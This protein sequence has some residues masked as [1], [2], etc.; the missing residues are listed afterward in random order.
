MSDGETRS[1]GRVALLLLV[2][3][4]LRL[5]LA[6]REAPEPPPAP[7]VLPGLLAESR[8]RAEEAAA[9]STPLGPKEQLDPNGA[10]AAELDRLPGVGPAIAEALVRSREAEG[11]FGGPEDLLRVP[12][13]G[14]ALLDRIRPHLALAPS[15]PAAGRL[16]P[17]GQQASAPPSRPAPARPAPPRPGPLLDVN[18]ADTLALQALP[19]VGPVLARRI[20]EARVESP[21]RSVDDLLRVRG[22]GPATLSRL[23]PLVTVPR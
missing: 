15:A 1:L 9:R 18:R 11:P 14:P 23:R 12:R 6:S 22:I 16:R 19:G 5:G 13:V 17:R 20:V 21:F 7:D 8:G 10:T 2:A 4:V 3:S